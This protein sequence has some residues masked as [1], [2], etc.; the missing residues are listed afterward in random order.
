MEYPISKARLQ[1]F[2]QEWVELERTKHVN[3]IVDDITQRVLAHATEY[4]RPNK[5]MRVSGGMESYRRYVHQSNFRMQN[6]HEHPVDTYMPMILVKLRERF[7]DCRIDM[8]PLQTY[9]IV[10]WS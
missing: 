9:I 10:D 4:S 3:K 2:Y 5:H 1:N 6:H 8:D 7:P